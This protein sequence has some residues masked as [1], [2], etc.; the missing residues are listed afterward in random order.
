MRFLVNAEHG[1]T[2]ER[3]PTGLAGEGGS[4]LGPQ[5]CVTLQVVPQVVFPGENLATQ[6]TTEDRLGEAG[7][8]AGLDVSLPAV[9]VPEREREGEEPSGQGGNKKF[10]G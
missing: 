7:T 5:A 4:R 8:S 9:F 2:T 6:T 1:F 3:G 10:D